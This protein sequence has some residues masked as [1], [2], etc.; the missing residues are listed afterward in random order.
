M[1][2]P[3]LPPDQNLS[4]DI[5]INTS[6]QQNL[7]ETRFQRRE[8]RNYSI[9][10]RP[11]HDN[12]LNKVI[13]PYNFDKK[14]YQIQES[15]I[16]FYEK[17]NYLLETLRK[18]NE[19]DSFKIEKKF[20]ASKLQKFCMYTP[21]ILIILLLIYLS[22][23]ILTLFS[24]NPVL[25]YTIYTCGRKFFHYLNMIQFIFLEKFKITEIKKKLQIEN[26]TKI[27]EQNKVKWILGQSG[28]W[29]ELQ[30]DM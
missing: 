8:N 17:K 6:F 25:I 16:E 3:L 10:C 24:F 28:Y 27:C 18:F 9:N 21:A 12:D 15:E 22:I 26:N 29:L 1:V 2:E 30:K 19:L 5:T 11:N 13:I 7:R 4:N 14:K 23:I 20:K